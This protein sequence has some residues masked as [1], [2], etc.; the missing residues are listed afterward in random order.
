ML[1]TG[2]FLG[3]N[4]ESYII[5]DGKAFRI[6][7]KLFYI[8]KISIFVIAHTKIPRK[9]LKMT[10]ENWAGRAGTSSL[11]KRI[12]RLSAK[13][14]IIGYQLC[15]SHLIYNMVKLVLE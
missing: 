6:A 13:N 15:L 5:Y 1:E 8:F 12:R 14:Y 9:Q 7:I 11:T 10:E 4:I 2:K 3:L